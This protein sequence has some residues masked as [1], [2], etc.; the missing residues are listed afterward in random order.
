MDKRTLVICALSC[1][2]WAGMAVGGCT[3]GT[4]PDCS[5]DA[6]CGPGFDGP[7]EDSDAANDVMDASDSGDAADAVDAPMETSDAPPDTPADVSD[8]GV[9]SGGGDSGKKKDSGKD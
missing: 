3:S 4:T 1:A 9:D 6:G 7:P 2:V 5:G 8:G